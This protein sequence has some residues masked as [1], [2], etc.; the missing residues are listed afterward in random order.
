MKIA[1]VV[2]RFPALSESFIVQQIT[3]LIDQDQTV[4]IFSFNQSQQ[5][6]IQKD[7]IDYK[8]IEKT[9]Y[10]T[11]PKKKWHLRLKGICWF[12]SIFFH[13]PGSAFSLIHCFSKKRV[14]CYPALM[15]LYEYFKD[16]PDA[17][18]AHFGPNAI[19]L[20]WLKKAGV[21][22]KLITTFHG[23]DVSVYVRQHGQDV[24]QELFEYGDLFTYNSEATKKK[25]LELGCPVERM[26][27]LPM[28]VNIDNIAF[29]PRHH[30]PADTVHILSVGRLVEMKGREYAV[31]AIAQ[32]KDK[33]SIR[34]DIV[35]D[36]P[37]HDDL[38]KLIVDLGLQDAVKLWG[39]VSTDQLKQLYQ[40]A[41]LFVHPSI[42]SSNGNQEGQGVVLL[43]AQAHGIPVIAT[44]HGAFPDSL[45][46]GLT[47]YL[48]PE[49]DTQAL[50]ERIDALIS[51]SHL[52]PQM[53]R[54]G[55]RFVETNFNAKTLN[56]KLLDLYRTVL[57][58]FK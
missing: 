46:D 21:N 15:L 48:V 38:H 11:P 7:V 55:R 18:H 53:G 37:L 50:V 41:H 40:N 34:Y 23:Y 30:D 36:G 17:F 43:E 16:K 47:G 33:Y 56:K 9:T 22:V 25:L 42:T 13:S 6:E 39:W 10:L 51:D 2:G 20:L 27:K 58:D 32:L 31:K 5:T 57:S 28:A 29:K 12:F 4:L 26:V 35:G 8:L 54:E 49:K 1:F 52:W 14:F 19:P 45:R 24:Y 3:A 44:E